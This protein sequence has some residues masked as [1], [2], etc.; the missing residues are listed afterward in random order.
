MN[1][2]TVIFYNCDFYNLEALCD[3]KTVYI[4]NKNENI[5]DVQNLSALK[6]VKNLQLSGFS[7]LSLQGLS[8]LDQGKSQK[9]HFKLS[10]TNGVIMHN[11][12]SDKRKDIIKDF[13]LSITGVC[14]FK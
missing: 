6:N 9:E 5:K 12:T 4:K 1:L 10:Q 8:E 2:E 14:I 11:F 3:A 7:E 13:H